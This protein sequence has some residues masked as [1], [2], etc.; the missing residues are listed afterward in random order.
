MIM[1]KLLFLLP[2]LMLV[3]GCTG[4]QQTSNKSDVKVTEY[5]DSVIISNV[6]ETKE[7]PQKG[8]EV[9]FV[10][11]TK[12]T[13]GDVENNMIAQFTEYADAISKGDS[14]K[15]FQYL[16]KD[17]LKHYQQ[18]AEADGER[19]SIDEIGEEMAESMNELQ[20]RFK[21]SGIKVTMVIPSLI[22]RID[23]GDNIFIVFTN[24]MNLT[25][26]GNSLHISPLEQSIGI[27]NNKGNNWTFVG[28]ED[29]I[30]NVLNKVYSEDVVN[31]VMDY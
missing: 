16:N 28:F 3:Y 29:D 12:N 10:E 30:A 24:V 17:F 11:Q 20:A 6:V 8:F 14:K 13:Y 19:F 5:S 1:R 4:N 2:L 26:D 7:A 22:R 21:N 23:D 15:C 9:G 25:K 27:S 31:A 18:L